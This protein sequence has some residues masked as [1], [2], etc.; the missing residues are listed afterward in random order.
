MNTLPKIKTL[1]LFSFITS[2]LIFLSCD[3]FDS[4]GN[5]IRPIEGNIIFSIKEGYENHNSISEPNIMLSMAT[6]KI[7]PC[8]NWS[9]ISEI[10]VWSD[11]IL[12]DLLDIHVPEICLT[13]LGP[14]RSTSFLDI[15]K[16]EY[17]LY[18]SY[19]DVTD[20]YVLTVTDSSIKI[21]EDGSQFTKPKFK[22]FWRYPP[23]SFVY[24][25]RTTTE[26]SWICEDFLDTLSSK[27]AIEEFQFPDSGEIPYLHSSDGHYYNIPAKYF[28]YKNDGD[29]DKA[30][31]ILKSY[32]QSVI[33]KYSGVGISLI[34]WKN[35]K[36][37]SWLF[38][39]QE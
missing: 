21:T 7:Y 3:T 10:T 16:G 6:E 37:H 1:A 30:G 27:I 28:S 2:L 5:E 12:I 19:K 26:T 4:S 23:N 29:F 14:A 32:T 9:I 34:N 36:Y 8:F 35:K 20:R 22:L 24:L 11:K 38:D 15:S 25:C 33:V 17:S 31:V 39:N 13:A 18:F